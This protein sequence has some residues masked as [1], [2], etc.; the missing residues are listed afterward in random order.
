M[1]TLLDQKLPAFMES[2]G[3]LSYSQQPISGPYPEPDASN[4]QIPTLFF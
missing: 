3:S 1:F 4:P 2:E